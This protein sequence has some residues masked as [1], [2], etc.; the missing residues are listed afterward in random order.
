MSDLIKSDV[1]T[2][3]PDQRSLVHEPSGDA[4]DLLAQLTVFHRGWQA[5]T[6]VSAEDD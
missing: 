3:I 4:F 1:A 2:P 6:D 5:A